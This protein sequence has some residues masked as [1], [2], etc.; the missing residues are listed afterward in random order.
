MLKLEGRIRAKTCGRVWFS[1]SG[2]AIIGFGIE[3]Q[4]N[5]IKK[6]KETDSLEQVL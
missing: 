3:K 6:I 1:Y 5:N 2:L 4:K